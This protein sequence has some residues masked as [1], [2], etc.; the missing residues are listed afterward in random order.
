MMTGFKRIWRYGYQ[1]FL[2]DKGSSVATVFVF[3]LTLSLLTSLLL[4]Q[5][6][7]GFLIQSIRDRVDVSA[8]FSD[9]ATEDTI[10]QARDRILELSEVR[11]VRYVSKE[12]ALATFT[13]RHAGDPVLLEAL[14]AVGTNPLLASLNIRTHEVGQ[15][16]GVVK[17]LKEGEFAPFI[18]KVDY[19]NRKPV[20]DRISALVAGIWA[21]GLA[22]SGVLALVA[23]LVAFNTVR[24]AIYNAKEEIEVMK[25]VGASHWFIRGPFLAQGVLA[26]AMGAL[27]VLF[28]FFPLTLVATPIIERVTQ[29]FNLFEYFLSHFF[30]TLLFLG[31]VGTG[32][33]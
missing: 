31:I 27:I 25:L 14:S 12:D 21:F 23:V 8:Y 19:E 29:G 26:G 30:T 22:L 7:S 32:L 6:V 10:L 11:D 18:E 33:G 16:D 1:A 17:S 5:G 28:M 15:F 20:I 13:E 2:R 24:L 3:V 4:F 9:A